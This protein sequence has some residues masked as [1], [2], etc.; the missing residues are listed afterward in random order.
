M[1]ATLTFREILPWILVG[2]AALLLVIFLIWYFR[3]RKKK[4]PIFRLRPRVQLKPHELALMALEKLRVKKLWQ[5][6]QEKAYYTELTDILRDYIENRFAVPA[7]EST[8]AE[9]LHDLLGIKEID[10]AVWDEL[11]QVLMLADMVKFAKEKPVSE[12]NE[13]ILETGIRFVNDTVFVEMK[14]DTGEE[15]KVAETNE[16]VSSLSD[17]DASND[18]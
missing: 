3:K 12:Q 10:R 2:L 13:N 5:Q 18:D 15:S 16:K 4:E 6:G 14:N 8:S 11:G 9:I 7:M 17:P 1:K